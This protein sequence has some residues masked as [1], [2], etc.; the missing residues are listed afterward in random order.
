MNRSR[1][2]DVPLR[3]LQA[4]IGRR[5]RALSAWARFRFRMREA[6]VGDVEISRLFRH[7]IDAAQKALLTEKYRELFPDAVKM[8][9]AEADRLSKHQ[10]KFL[11]HKVDH[12]ERVAWSRDPVSRLDW[13]HGFSS[14][15]AYRGPKRLGDI[16]LPWELNKHQYFFTLGKAAWLAGDPSLSVEI[17]RQIGHWI[18]DNPYQRGINWV[19]ALETGTRA[20]SWIMAFP[21]YADSCNASFRRRLAES[22]AQHMLFVEEHLSTGRFANTHLIGEAATLV[23]GGLFLDCRQSEGWLSSG[24]ALLEQEMERQVTEDGVH[25]ER[26][27]GYHRFFLDHF[28][29]VKAL[30][31]AN[32]QSFAASTVRGMERMTE[33]LLDLLSPDMSAPAFGDGDD[34]R[35]L[36]TRADCPAEYRSLLALGAVLFNRE[37]F[38]AVAGHLTEEVLWLLGNEGVSKFQELASTPPD[39]TSAA[40]PDGG[41]YVM[42]GGWGTSD[43]QMVFRCGPI[44]HGPAGHGHADALSYCLYAS[45][46]GFIVD[47]GTFSYNLDYQWRD[48]FRSTRAHNT[49]VVDGANQSVTGDRMSW[50]S[51]AATRCLK[52]VTTPSFDLVSGEHDGY[53]RLRDPVMHQRAVAFLKPDTWGLLDHLHGKE[54]HSFEI[55]M[56]LRPDCSVELQEGHA[57]VV[58]RSPDGAELYAWTFD[59]AGNACLPEVLTGSDEERAAWFSPGYGTRLPTKALRIR[60]EFEKRTTV[61]TCL[62][63]SEVDVHAIISRDGVVGATIRRMEGSKETLFY[64]LHADWPAGEEGIHFDGEHLYHRAIR[65]GTAVLSA[66]V[67]CSLSV[68]GL[69]D[70]RSRVP[71]DSLIL[72]NGVC[73]IALAAGDVTHLRVNARD[74]LRVLV[75]GRPTRIAGIDS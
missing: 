19:S 53:Q 35:A 13:G 67:F 6:D 69:L 8:E 66:S 58:L 2:D 11:G 49:V 15:I 30:L 36:W 7:P 29:V 34:S 17:V 56:H 64:R 16:K 20:I 54:A 31:G 40:Y 39:H 21:F 24:L 55:Y 68:A 3:N 70:V 26:S 41:Y 51:V 37:D 27:I 4:R 14:D 25:V 63:T 46:Y 33:F 65:A 47:S 44:G 42:R 57:G 45:A 52:W 59:A 5:L 10:F 22:L 28:H 71:I 9:L 74:R 75:N 18:E 12:G 60:G 32:E 72:Q 61:F 1:R 50:K 62:S 43:P 48:A 23:A 38:K 73:E